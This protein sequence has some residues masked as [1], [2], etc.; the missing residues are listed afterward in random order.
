MEI[1][2]ILVW[3]II[4]LIMVL[5]EFAI[6]GLIVVFFGAGAWVTAILIAIFPGMAV[7]VQ[8]MIFTVLSIVSLLLLRR[9]LKRH[10]FSEQEGAESE[11]LDD[12]IGRTAT[13]EKAIDNGVGKVSFKGASWD[14]YS[15]VDIPE[16]TSVTII[17]KDSIKLKVKPVK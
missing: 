10:F 15:D 11:G 9:L 3:F 7:W 6:P 12:Y 5:M 8:L 1:S 14:A 2:P 16:G 4:G 13:V 17:D